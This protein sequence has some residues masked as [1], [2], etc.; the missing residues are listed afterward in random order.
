MLCKACNLTLQVMAHVAKEVSC[1]RILCCR[2]SRGHNH[3]HHLQCHRLHVCAFGL[4]FF[5]P[6]S[7]VMS[8]CFLAT[9]FPPTAT[10][11][12][13]LNL[14]DLCTSWSLFSSPSYTPPSPSEYSVPGRDVMYVAN[15]YVILLWDVYTMLC[16]LPCSICVLYIYC[17]PGLL[18]QSYSV[19]SCVYVVSQILYECCAT[20][21]SDKALAVIVVVECRHSFCRTMI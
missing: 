10:L 17:W 16:F 3:H 9:M 4:L 8:H 19:S 1:R 21:Y 2:C 14:C 15:S 12:Q 18:V 6:C 7:R 11:P 5:P 20:A 13:A